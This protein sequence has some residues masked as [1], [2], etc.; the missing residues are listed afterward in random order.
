VTAGI[1]PAAISLAAWL[2]YPLAVGLGWLIVVD[3]NERA[4]AMGRAAAL[5]TLGSKAAY[6]GNTVLETVTFGWYDAASRTAQTYDEAVAIGA[7]RGRRAVLAAWALAAAT[8]AFAVLVHVAAGLPAASAG[9]AARRAARHLCLAG[10]VLFVTGLA[11]TSLSLV[12]SQD[13]PGIGTVVFRYEAKSILSTIRGLL[14]SH[15]VVLGGLVLVFSVVVPLCKAALLLF[16]T[17]A[18]GAAGARAVAI[19]HAVGRWSM[20]DVF[21]VAVL[22]A[23]LALGRDPSVRA[24]TGP[25]LYAFAG[26]CLLSLWAAAWLPHG[27]G[28]AAERGLRW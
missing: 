26:S 28:Q 21:A 19:V 1:P 27:P 16:A 17:V 5:E 2:Y 25:G 4:V 20:A 12:T 8:T 7:A 15:D 13:V 9:A 18:P 22:L 24:A 3:T 10:I 14:E 11:A 6:A 23:M